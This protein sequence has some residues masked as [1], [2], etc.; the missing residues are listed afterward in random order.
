MTRSASTG[1]CRRSQALYKEGLDAYRRPRSRR[2]TSL[3]PRMRLAVT[4]IGYLGLTHA[5]CLAD[6]GHEVLAIDV[7]QDKVAKAANG[8]APFF[9][10]GLEPLLRKKLDG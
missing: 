8:V 4:G 2:M 6:L 7:D 10:P 1:S 9:E 5:V 3:H